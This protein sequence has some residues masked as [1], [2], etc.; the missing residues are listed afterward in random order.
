MV[1]SENIVDYP[2]VGRVRYVRNSRARNILIRINQ[3]GEVRVTVPGYVS[4]KK[5]E[6]FFLSKKPWVKSKIEA[7]VSVLENKIK[8]GDILNVKGKS[9][10][11]KLKNGSESVEE[12]VW[13]I[14]HGEARAYLPGRVRMLAK[15]NGFRISGV[16]IRRMKTRWGSCNAKNNINL[17]SWLM[18]LPDHLSDYVILHE[19]VHTRHKNHSTRFWESLDTIT[20]GRS[21]ALRKEL[22]K[23]QIMSVDT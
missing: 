7:L 13:R 14:L 11:V 6:V 5:A 18:M 4:L 1:K 9:V 17:N 23:Q 16:K 10:P 8:E 3:Q 12:A 15:E 20:G 19:L 2:S 22:G 21:K